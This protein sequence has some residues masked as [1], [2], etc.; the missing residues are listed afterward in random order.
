MNMRLT[1]KPATGEIMKEALRQWQAWPLHNVF[2][3][4][5]LNTQEHK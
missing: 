1:A 5:L 3:T 4:W 2:Y